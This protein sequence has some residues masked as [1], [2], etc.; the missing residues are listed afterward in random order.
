MKWQGKIET[1]LSIIEST[2][3]GT[4]ISWRKKHELSKL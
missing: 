4:Y 1:M 3:T 2:V